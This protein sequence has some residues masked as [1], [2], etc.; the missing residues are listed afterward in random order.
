MNSSPVI[1]ANCNRGG[2]RDGRNILFQFFQ[3]GGVMKA[4]FIELGQMIAAFD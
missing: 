1:A 4:E 2:M 3:G